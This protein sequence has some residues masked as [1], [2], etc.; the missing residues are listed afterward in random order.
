M[1]ARCA[2][3]ARSRPRDARAQVYQDRVWTRWTCTHTGR[4]R[5]AA[6]G[7]GLVVHSGLPKVT[8]LTG[9]PLRKPAHFRCGAH[10]SQPATAWDRPAAVARHTSTVESVLSRRLARLT[11]AARATYTP[12]ALHSTAMPASAQ[13]PAILGLDLAAPLSAVTVS[14]ELPPNGD[15][16][17]SPALEDTSEDTIALPPQGSPRPSGPSDH[18]P[19]S[20]TPQKPDAG[21]A[22]PCRRQTRTQQQVAPL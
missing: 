11:K 7:P 16:E 2:G 1:Q 17:P 20:S 22:L 5:R 19:H 10:H 21:H 15:D 3:C 8:T 12:Q 18:S 4:P 6:Q 14:A 13:S 9:C